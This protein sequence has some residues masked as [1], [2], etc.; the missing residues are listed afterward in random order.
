LSEN[1]YVAT[2]AAQKRL[3]EVLAGQFAYPTDSDAMAD[4]LLSAPTV[5]IEYKARA[6]QVVITLDLP[7]TATVKPKATETETPTDGG[8]AVAEATPEPETVQAP[9][10]PHIVPY[11]PSADYEPAEDDVH[12]D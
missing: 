12:F 5:K 3:R 4:V 8:E 6:K 7:D 2:A 1:D 9:P 11:V 10:Q